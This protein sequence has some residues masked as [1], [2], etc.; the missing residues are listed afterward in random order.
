MRPTLVT[1]AST[2]CGIAA[3]L[4]SAVAVPTGRV[5]EW[6]CGISTVVFDGA[7]HA[8]QGLKC[9]DCHPKPFMMKKDHADMKMR[10]LIEGKYCGECHD[11]KRAFAS[12][13]AKD[14]RRCHKM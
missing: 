4:S 13:T 10:E 12:N 9:T 2:L 1:V 3:L 8:Q 5:L 6:K 11:G 7:A 14:C